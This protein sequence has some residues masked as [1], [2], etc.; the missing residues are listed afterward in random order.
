MSNWPIF[1]HTV[2]FNFFR[3][4][5][6]PEYWYIPRSAKVAPD[7]SGPRNKMIKTDRYAPDKTQ[8]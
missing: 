3:C 4:L 1:L 2:W 6:H 8:N 5:P 7:P